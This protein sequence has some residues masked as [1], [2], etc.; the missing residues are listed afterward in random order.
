MH[1]LL[2]NPK[3]KELFGKSYMIELSRLAQGISGISKGTNTIILIG[4]DKIPNNRCKYV[5]YGRV[6]INYHPEKPNPN[7]ACLT[8]GGNCITYTG[9]CG[10]PIVNMVTV[11]IHLNSIVSTKGARYCTIDLKDFYLNTPMVCPEF[12]RMK[13]TEFPEDFAQIY[14]LHV[15]VNANGFVSIE[16]QKGMYGLPQASILA[17]ELL[18]KCLNKHGYC[19]SSITLGL[20]QHDFHPISFTL[21]IEDFGIKYVGCEHVEHLSSILSEHYKCSQ[22]RDSARY[23]GMNI[24]WDYINKNVHVS[25]LDYVPEALIRFQHAPPAKASTPTVSSRQTCVGC[26]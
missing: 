8:V 17:Q 7:L 15:L 13:L 5:T 19:Q 16:I 1:H 20:W 25:M 3:Y 10:T 18:E 4:Q 24:G 12:M 11:K 26:I 9:D 21:C 22:D 2:V 14:K 23:L 6:C